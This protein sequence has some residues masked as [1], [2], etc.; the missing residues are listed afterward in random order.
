MQEVPI[1]SLGLALAIQA[2]G[3]PTLLPPPTTPPPPPPSPPSPRSPAA[4]PLGIG[5]SRAV[6]HLTIGEDGRVTNCDIKESTGNA[7]V[8]TATCRIAFQRVKYSARI[9]A[10]PGAPLRTVDLPVRWQ[11]NQ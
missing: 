2:V 3:P 1:L 4:T 10:S 11:I 9:D 7:A 5:P 6:V 8:D